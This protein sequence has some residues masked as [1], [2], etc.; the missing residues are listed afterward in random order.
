MRTMAGDAAEPYRC[1]AVRIEKHAAMMAA[2][3]GVYVRLCPGVPSTRW[4]SV[5][6]VGVCPAFRI[7]NACAIYSPEAMHATTKHHLQKT[8]IFQ[9]THIL[10]QQTKALP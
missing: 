10:Q 8:R 3:A 5:A 4:T 1:K 6:A 2:V 9:R 7:M